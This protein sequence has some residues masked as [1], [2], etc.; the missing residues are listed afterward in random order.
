[1]ATG[2]FVDAIRG[3]RDIP[4]TSVNTGARP[5][6]DAVTA[7]VRGVVEAEGERLTVLDLER[8]LLA[9]ELRAF[10]LV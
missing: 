2:L 5:S 4:A 10:E 7:Y 6:E 8:L 9:P 1:V 3:L